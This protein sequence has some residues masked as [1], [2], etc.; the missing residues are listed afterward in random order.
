MTQT[1]SFEGGT[2]VRDFIVMVTVIASASVLVVQ[3]MQNWSAPWVY[4]S[5]RGL[6]ITSADPLDKACARQNAVRW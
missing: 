2:K 5:D 4:G 6:C 1:G 3:L